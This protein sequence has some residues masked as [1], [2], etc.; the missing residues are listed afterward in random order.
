MS[1]SGTQYVHCRVLRLSKL[2][3]PVNILLG[4]QSDIQYFN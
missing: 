4:S 2:T 1:R 3:S